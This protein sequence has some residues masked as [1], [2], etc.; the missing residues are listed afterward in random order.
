[1]ETKK[2]IFDMLV[3][4]TGAHFLDSGGA[5]GRHHE[6]NAKKTFDDFN[7]EPEIFYA[8]HTWKDKNNKK[9]YE[10]ERTVSVFHFLSELEVD[11]I[12]ENFLPVIVEIMGEKPFIAQ[13]NKPIEC[14]GFC[15]SLPL[16]I[17]THIP[18]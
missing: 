10:I 12:C 7:S 17:C 2:I 15:F 5:Y 11:E 8:L 18:A 3:E 16:G 1:M 6:R 13:V 4:N 14:S 9:R